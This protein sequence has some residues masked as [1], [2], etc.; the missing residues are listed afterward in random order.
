MAP[1]TGMSGVSMSATG[2]SRGIDRA[3]TGAGR[4]SVPQNSCWEDTSE[5]SRELSMGPWPVPVCLVPAVVR[6]ESAPPTVSVCLGCV[7]MFTSK[8]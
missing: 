6:A 8:L 2:A 4:A 3:A 1:V 5:V 7:C